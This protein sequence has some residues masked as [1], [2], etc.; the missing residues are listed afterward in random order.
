MPEP[1]RPF[2]L[3]AVFAWIDAHADACIADLQELVRQPSV[4]AQGIGLQA[5]ADLVEAQM[6]RDGLDAHQHPLDG[7]PPV[8]FGHMTTSRSSKTMMCYSHYD[9][10]PPEPLEAWS[11]G[12]PWSAAIV[13]GVMYGR[14][15]SDNKS[16]ILAFNKAAQAF[17]ATHGE[18]PVNLKFLCEGEEEVGSIH[19]GPWVEANAALLEADG[20]H[21]LDGPMDT[22]TELPDVDLGLKSVLFVELVARGANSDIH[23]LNFPLVPTPVWDLVRALNT[24][25]DDRRRILIDGWTDGLYELQP[26]D[27]ADLEEKAARVDTGAMKREWGITEFALLRDG[28]EAHHARAYEPTANIA[29]LVAGYT[30]KG[31]KTIVPNEARAKM[32]FRLIPHMRQEE[33]IEK[34]RAHLDRHGFGHIEVIGEARAE[35][36][37][38]I[39]AKEPMAQAVIAAANACTASGRSSTASPPRAPSCATCGSPAC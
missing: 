25:M 36:P 13:D 9:V 32:D 18:L 27:W 2:D 7:G 10:Q 8:I 39:S 33:A 12:G 15:V 29:G 23:S 20:M 14:G 24:I 28:I 35:P 6:R 16:G 37:Y 19:L 34:L 21:C 22:A 30:G 11:H 3:E 38:K 4:S 26:E 1:G 31:S 5:C 17:L